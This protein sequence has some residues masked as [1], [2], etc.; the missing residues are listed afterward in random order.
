MFTFFQSSTA[1][2]TRTTPDCATCR[3]YESC[4]FPKQTATPT[5]KRTVVVVDEV[6]EDVKHGI[7]VPVKY[8]RLFQRVAFSYARDAVVPATACAG[9]GDKD[10]QHCQPLLIDFIKKQNPE[11]I[12]IAGYK[13]LQSVIKWLWGEPAGENT[14]WYGQVIPSR[15]LN[16]WVHIPEWLNQ[17]SNRT[18]SDIW[19]FRWAKA[20]RD[21]TGRPYTEVPDY[22]KMYTVVYDPREL[23]RYEQEI[24][25][26][27]MTAFDI[28]TTGRKPEGECHSIYSAA[29]A[30]LRQ[31]G[32]THCV[33]FLV[34][35][36]TQDFLIRYLQSPIRKIG[37]NNKFEIRWC[38]VKL[39]TDIRNFCWDT[40]VSAHIEDARKGVPGVKF[41]SFVRLGLKHYAHGMD[42]YF[43]GDTNTTT[44]SIYSADTSMVLRY[45]AMDSLA[46]L[47][48]GILQMR[49]AGILQN[50]TTNNLPRSR[51]A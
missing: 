19:A 5:Q 35:D 49:E 42:Q 14:R 31:D 37:A 10:W 6:T 39:G 23:P 7:Q 20:A 34:T 29:I 25:G 11:K 16:A 22:E 41:Q 44:N 43:E 24:L 47:D 3:A 48:L 40:V 45:N 8:Q 13:A 28:E 30:Y 4:K 32:S 51:D 27:R 46:E 1:P 2:A 21:C 38:R 26:S 15:E 33:S 12:V 36:E 9:A 17:Y 50:L 18:V